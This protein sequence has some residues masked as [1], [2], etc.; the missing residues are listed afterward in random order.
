MENY[1]LHL[2]VMI[3]LYS[4]LTYSVN[5]SAGY[6]GLISFCPAAFYGIGAYTYA[7]LRIG[8]TTNYHASDFLYAGS[9]TFLVSLGGAAIVGGLTALLVGCVALRFRGDFFVFTTLGFQMI[10]FALLYN[11]TGLSR[12]SLGI[13]GIPRPEI[14]G[15][16]VVDVGDYAMLIGLANIS[17]LPTLWLLCRSPFGRRLRALRDNERAAESLGVSAFRQQLW[18]FVIASSFAAIAGALFASYL[19]YIDPTSFT[20]RESILIVSLLLLGGSGNMKGPIVGT[21]VMLLLPEAL[22]FLGIPGSIAPSVREIIYGGALV[23]LMLWR[24]KGLAGDYG[25]R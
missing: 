3:G 2:T 24:P 12:G 1:I 7:L 8:Q 6:G 15:W 11:W 16:K 21:F 9:F 14:F 22:R 20:L 13:A 23:L 10:V 18:A 5:L 17:L 19:T 4:I 25:L